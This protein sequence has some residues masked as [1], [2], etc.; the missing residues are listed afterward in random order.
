MPT[1]I[2]IIE[3]DNVATL[4]A[5]CS[6]GEEV[7]VVGQEPIIKVHAL[8]CIEAGHKV[9]LSSI[10]S[11]EKVVKFSTPIGHALREIPVGAWV[12]LHNLGSDHDVRSQTFN[13]RSGAP[14]DSVYR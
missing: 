9:A 10:H 12:H 2:R 13:L 4:V 3:A 7:L 14:T 1:A 8:E 11:G 6:A 5:A